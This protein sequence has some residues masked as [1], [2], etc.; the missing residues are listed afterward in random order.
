MQAM[1][2]GKL[3]VYFNTSPAVKLLQ[4]R[5]APYTIA[6][7][8]QQFK[9]SGAIAVP[10][11]ELLAALA[12]WLEDVQALHEDAPRD[13]PET[14]LA[15]WCSA[16]KRWLLRRF[17]A[18]HNEPVYELSP[19]TE[20]VFAFLDR[21]L[22][23]DL[24]FV[25]TESR[26]HLVI[27]ILDDVVIGASGDPAVHLD[28]LRDE[29]ERVLQQI[30][31]IEREGLV[32]RYH[33]ARIR[34]RFATAVSLLKQLQGD[35]RAVEERFREITRQVQQ[36]QVHSHET[37]GGILGDALDAEDALKQEDQ[38]VSFFEFLRF[39][40]SPAQQERLR[41]IIQQLVRIRELADQAD[42]IEAVRRM[43]PS[44]LAEAEKVTH[45]TRRL[46]STLRRLLD[47]RAR[48]ERQRV[49]ELLREIQGLAA[50]LAHDPPRDRVALEVDAAIETSSPFTRTF[51]SE[52]ARFESVNLT[53]HLAD[54]DQRLEA[55]RQL[56][57]LHRIDWRMLRR[58]VRDAVTFTG[59]A[60]LGELLDKYPPQS[61]LT[62]VLGYLQ[63]ASDDG[64]L[65]SR[66]AVEEIVVPPGA[67]DRRPLLV[68]VPLVTFVPKE[69]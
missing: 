26:L 19:H 20:E 41:I 29:Q 22:E 24:G 60:T 53:E 10:H 25:A 44:L 47:A 51:W 61:G 46:S 40:H 7:L 50:G 56:A 11:S 15:D 16:E 65:I 62:D 54:D 66:E 17:D 2:P 27:Q 13:R 58:Q 8:H 14:Y 37:R 1:N 21:T 31:Q 4:A 23:Q 18:G 68:T 6:F 34:E 39:I 38:G 9:R 52:P 67:D 28:H 32:S 49:A 63:I 45:T 55:F 5:N 3:L 30:A 64:H 69:L 48:R 59:R 12:N 33:P 35:F 36:R 42:G 43:V 57:R